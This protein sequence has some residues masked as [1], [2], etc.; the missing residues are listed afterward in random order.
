MNWVK[1]INLGEAEIQGV[2]LKTLLRFRGIGFFTAQGEI[3]RPIDLTPNSSRYNSLI[4]GKPRYSGLFKIQ[5]DDFPWNAFLQYRF[6]G[7]ALLYSDSEEELSFQECIDA[8]ISLPIYQSLVFSLG[9]QN[10]LDKNL[11]DVAGYPLPGRTFSSELKLK[12]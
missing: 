2:D 8:G 12:I 7:G 5:T 4:P 9:V 1:A 6:A 10:L 11:E 3:L